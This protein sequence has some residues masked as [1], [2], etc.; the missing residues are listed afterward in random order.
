MARA[1]AIAGNEAEAREWLNRA[2]AGTAGVANEHDRALLE[3]D[4]ATAL[5]ETGSASG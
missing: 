2:R 5:S 3:A 4:L 1:H